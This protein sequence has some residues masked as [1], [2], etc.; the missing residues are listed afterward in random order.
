MVGIVTD[1]LG[2]AN[3]FSKLDGNWRPILAPLPFCYRPALLDGTLARANQ[4]CWRAVLHRLQNQ[5]HDQPPAGYDPCHFQ[6]DNDGS[7]LRIIPPGAPAS[8]ARRC[9]PK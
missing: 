5:G 8:S 7:L 2:D 6:V 1:P 4:P 9:F 3:K